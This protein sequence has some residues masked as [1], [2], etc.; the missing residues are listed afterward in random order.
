MAQQQPPPNGTATAQQ[1]QYTYTPP[2]PQLPYYNALFTIADKSSVGYLSGPQAVEF[3]S[4]SKLPIELLK[5]IWTMADQPQT[6]T[7]D[8]SKFHVAVRLIQLFQNGKKPIDLSLNVGDGNEEGSMRPPFFEGVNVQAVMQA[9]QQQAQQQQQQPLQNQPTPQ[10]Q[11]QPTQSSPQRSPQSSPQ[12]GPSSSSA[13]AM[14][15]NGGGGHPSSSATVLTVQDPYTMTPQELSR[16]ET[17]FPSYAV[18]DESD[19]RYY[20]NGGTAVE[21]FSKS[22]EFCFLFF[23]FVCYIHG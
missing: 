22:G 23:L 8:T 7:L 15:M 5:Q 17:L 1:P 21:L 20:V 14:M 12:M 4:T 13:S 16:Y 3:L 2:P 11:Q 18:Q 6:N 19:G 10:L 9:Q